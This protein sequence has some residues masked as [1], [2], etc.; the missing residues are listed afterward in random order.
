[1]LQ[2]NSVGVASANSWFVVPGSSATNGMSFTVD[3]A[4]KNVFYRLQH[5]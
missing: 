3:P 1:L 4:K 5:P 2:S